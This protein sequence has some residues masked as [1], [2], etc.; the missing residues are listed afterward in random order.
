MAAT[1]FEAAT[2]IRQISNDRDAQFDAFMN[3]HRYSTPVWA[4]WQVMSPWTENI[5]HDIFVRDIVRDRLS[6]W[7]NK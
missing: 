4:M 7:R 1:R 5:I 6:Q 2:A 3:Y